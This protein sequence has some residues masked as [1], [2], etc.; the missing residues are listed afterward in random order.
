[1]RGADMNEPTT[2]VTWK[3]RMINA[4]LAGI[5]S[6]MD[7]MDHAV[8]GESTAL[9]LEVY[10]EAIQAGLE[11]P[12]IIRQWA[13]TADLAGAVAS[14]RAEIATWT[15]P[16]RPDS[17]GPGSFVMVRRQSIESFLKAVFRVCWGDLHVSPA[18]IAGWDEL[19][20]ELA[21]FDDA[22]R[23]RRVAVALQRLRRRVPSADESDAAKVVA[24]RCAEVRMRSTS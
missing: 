11:T 7:V 1:M 15:I 9:V 12:K 8:T 20:H 23:V 21:I 4:A 22:I 13:R 6:V 3:E 14:E 19:A 5:A 2:V 16:V 17:D 24:L 18:T 10:G